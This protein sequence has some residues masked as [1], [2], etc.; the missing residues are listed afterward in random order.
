MAACSDART[1]AISSFLSPCRELHCSILGFAASH[2]RNRSKYRESRV[3]PNLARRT[4]ALETNVDNST[5]PRSTK[6]KYQQDQEATRVSSGALVSDAT[7]FVSQQA[8]AVYHASVAN[9]EAFRA[10]IE[11]VDRSTGEIGKFPRKQQVSKHRFAKR[12][13][14]MRGFLE[15]AL[16]QG[17]TVIHVTATEPNRDC[18]PKQTAQRF[19]AA[20]RKCTKATERRAITFAFVSA[21]GPQA[22]GHTHE[23]LVFACAAEWSDWLIQTV[24]DSFGQ[25]VHVQIIDSGEN[26]IEGMSRYLA[27]HLGCGGDERVACWS[28]IHGIRQARFSGVA[29]GAS[30]AWDLLRSIKIPPPMSS[31][32]IRAMW[33]AARAGAG[34]EFFMACGGLG[35][36]EKRQRISVTKGLS[37]STEANEVLISIFFLGEELHFVR[38]RRVLVRG[39]FETKELNQNDAGGLELY[40]CKDYCACGNC[41][42][43]SDKFTAP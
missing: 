12:S 18:S 36:R 16:S 24:R 23:H 5:S 43:A 29:P 34:A 26:S 35:V 7:K 38:E 17:L 39:H 30:S 14:W 20:R 33:I 4:R 6:R 25:G 42:A 1:H 31:P 22:S 15:Q 28:Y 32:S 37:N 8:L 27:R 13:A 40:S 3:L 9:R 41:G 2:S 19:A 21:T 11:L 10:G